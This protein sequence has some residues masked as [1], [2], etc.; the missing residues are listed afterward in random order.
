MN[1]TMPNYVTL[2]CEVALYAYN[3][4]VRRTIDLISIEKP[5]TNQ[6]THR[7]WFV[8]QNSVWKEI[9]RDRW[10]RKLPI[11]KKRRR[12]EELM[13]AKKS[14]YRTDIA[15]CKR[16]FTSGGPLTTVMGV[17]SD[18]VLERAHNTVKHWLETGSLSLVTSVRPLETKKLSEDDGYEY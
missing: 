15:Q 17:S 6:Y 9:N 13:R 2:A 3:D 14:I 16:F 12:F 1:D 8:I 18:K 5:D 7:R 11:E 10:S 4:L